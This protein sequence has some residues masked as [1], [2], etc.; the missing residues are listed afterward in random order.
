MSSRSKVGLD[1]VLM[2]HTYRMG[3]GAT[4]GRWL[5]GVTTVGQNYYRVDDLICRGGPSLWGCIYL[6]ISYSTVP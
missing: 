1:D 5:L 2:A 4:G 3:Y 6:F